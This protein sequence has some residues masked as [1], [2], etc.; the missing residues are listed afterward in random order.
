MPTLNFASPKV[1]QFA[2]DIALHWLDPNGDGKLSEG[3]DGFRCDVA[4][5]PP[6]D[7]WVQLRQAVKA[8]NPDAILLGELWTSAK[9]ISA[10]MQGD[11]FDAAFDF[12][13]YKTLEASQDQNND[14]L[15]A[16]NGSG[17]IAAFDLKVSAKL[18]A[19]GTYMVRFLGN[20]DTNRVMS[21]VNG[22]MA[23][24]SRL[25]GDGA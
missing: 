24:R 9:A 11:E 17:A 12:P 7:F 15:L 16:G 3:V 13:A 19:S 21:E 25:A 2:I 18:Y 8:K 1:R 5:G 23:R 20:H 10:H 4:V 22:D 14:G 6:P